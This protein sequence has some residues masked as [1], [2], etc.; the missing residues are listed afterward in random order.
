MKFQ[1][2]HAIEIL[3]RTPEALRAQLQGLSDAWLHATEGPDTFSPFDVVGHL[4]AGEE[5]D[6][7]ARAKRLLEHGEDLPFEPFDRFS[8]RERYA[9]RDLD[10]RLDSFAIL[11]EENLA[12]LRH[13]AEDGTD[14]EARGMHPELGG[15]CLSQLLATWVVHDLSHHAQISRVLA[16]QYTEAVGPWRAYLPLLG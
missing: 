13:L 1:Y 12:Y 7:V 3:S 10:A 16:R 8:F 4:L 5:E 6:W 2:D 14:L 9:N 11:R 15:V